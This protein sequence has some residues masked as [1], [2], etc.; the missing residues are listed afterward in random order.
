MI[1]ARNLLIAFN[2]NLQTADVGIAR[3]IA[4]KIRASSGGLAFVKAMGVT[5]AS[6]GLAQVSMNLTNFEQTGL[7]QAYSAVQVEAQTMGVSIAGIEIIGLVPKKAVDLA[8]A[9][10]P[11]WKNFDRGLILENR[12]A[13]A[14]GR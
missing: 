9:R 6:R 12:I 11:W 4:R 8:A 13:Q 10:D 7:D 5:L 3:A 2:I 14:R 1:G